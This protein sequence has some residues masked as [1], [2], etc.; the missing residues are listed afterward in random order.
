MGTS[1]GKPITGLGYMELTGYAERFTKSCR[2]QRRRRPTAPALRRDHTK[3][4][5]VQRRNSFH[6][7]ASPDGTAAHRRRQAE[8]AQM[9]NKCGAHLSTCRGETPVSPHY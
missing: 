5:S 1:G 6:S 4:P 8:P 3:F 9:I 2:S 7:S